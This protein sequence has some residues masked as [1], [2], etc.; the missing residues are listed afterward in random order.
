[1]LCYRFY[2]QHSLILLIIHFCTITEYSCNQIIQDAYAVFEI[3]MQNHPG[4]YNKEDLIFKEKLQ[5]E[6]PKIIAA[7]QNTQ[8]Y[9]K[10]FTILHQWIN[11]FDDPHLRL[12]NAAQQNPNKSNN[13]DNVDWFWWKTD[14]FYMKIP[15]FT[16]NKKDQAELKSLLKILPD[17]QRSK[18][19]VFDVRG[20]GGGSSLWAKKITS[21][22]FGNQYVQEKTYL[23]EKDVEIDWRATKDNWLYI[24]N[25]IPIIEEQFGKKSVEYGMITQVSNGIE[26]SIK[27]KKPFFTESPIQSHI[28][29]EE[30]VEKKESLCK[31]HIFVII[32]EKC[33]SATLSFIDQIKA[34]ACQ[35]TLIGQPTAY[36]TEYMECRSQNLPSNK[37]RLIFPIKVYRNRH[38]KSRQKY[39]PDVYCDFKKSSFELRKYV[40]TYLL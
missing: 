29:L 3:I 24:K 28:P 1:M 11:S 39:I 22:L 21:F 8:E 17:I 14:T 27:N 35:C 26:E 10:G 6:F 40:L 23:Y 25:V 16:F 12:V 7:L 13:T 38:R 31:A 5:N 33:A 30:I 37:A 4:I 18:N 20:N 34:V 2:K 36:D 15:S 32:D 19:I 9:E